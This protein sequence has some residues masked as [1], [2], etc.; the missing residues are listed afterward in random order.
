MSVVR[1]RSG[2]RQSC[3]NLSEILEFVLQVTRIHG[4]ILSSLLFEISFLKTILFIYFCCTVHSLLCRLFL[5]CG[6]W[7]LLAVV[8]ELLVVVA[9]LL[10]QSTGSRTH[11]SVAAGSWALGHRLKSCMTGLV[12]PQ[13]KKSSWIVDLNPSPALA[14]RSPLSHQGSPE[15]L[16][17]K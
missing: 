4:R 9:S 16:V 7:E 8:G 15:I 1:N 10:L 2:H 17:L 11:G 6:K 13:C 5:S 14:G 3:I 12:V